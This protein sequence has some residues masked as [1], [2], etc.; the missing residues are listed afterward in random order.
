[1]RCNCQL[2]ISKKLMGLRLKAEVVANQLYGKRF[3]RATAAKYA[4]VF[5]FDEL[6]LLTGKGELVAAPSADNKRLKEENK[7][8]L[9][10]IALQQETIN[11]LSGLANLSRRHM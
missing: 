5:G 2:P 11:K 6:F 9:A 4:T 1:M 10:I 8:L 7:K 3:G